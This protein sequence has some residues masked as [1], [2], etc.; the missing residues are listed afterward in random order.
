MTSSSP[1]NQGAFGISRYVDPVNLRLLILLVSLGL[2][3]S[4]L[5]GPKIYSTA[6]LQS[7][8]FQL[9][10]LGLLSLA[11]MIPLLTGGLDLS[12]I[13]T[14]NIC[15]LAMAAI[16]TTFLPGHTGFAWVALQ[17]V[18]VLAGALIAAL[19]GAFNGYL[20]AYMRV[21]PIL[22]TLG[23]M[24]TI[25]GIAV[26]LTHGGVISGL[27]SSIIYL[28]HGT[29]FGIPVAVL[30][31]IAVAIPVGILVAKTPFGLSVAMIGSNE[32]ATRFSGINTQRVILK[33]YVLSSMLAA[34]AGLVMMA[35]FDS[36]NA[37]YGESYLLV[38]ILAAVLGGVSPLGG[39][40]R[41]SG[42]VLSLMVLQL[43]STAANMLDL[44]QFLTL[45]IWGAI[46]LAVSGFG[47]VKTWYAQKIRFKLPRPIQ[48]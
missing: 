33:T 17:I 11:M 18:A 8:A 35:R 10:E 39:F 29:L 46:L 4:Q 31:F 42:L 45:S 25:K 14:S 32:K 3:F 23:S 38:T 7:M 47:L 16:L 48:S 21:P 44:S 28:G 36:A 5:I 15:A 30:I 20:I 13:A 40:G 2:V 22:A 12:I 41:V 34:C 9:P 43:I 6:S 26:G 19:I 27:P 1:S 37:A 24:T